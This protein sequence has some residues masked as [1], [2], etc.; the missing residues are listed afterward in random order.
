[1]VAD[2]VA[3]MVADMAAIM[4]VDMA[5][6]TEVMAEVMDTDMVT[7]FPMC[8]NLTITNRTITNTTE[9]DAV[10]SSEET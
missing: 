3:I 6:T 2:M 8:T 9:M 7:M 4:V 10:P 1:M 5:A